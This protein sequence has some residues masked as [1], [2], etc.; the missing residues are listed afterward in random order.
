MDQL[1][2]NNKWFNCVVSQNDCIQCCMSFLSEPY[3][4]Y[5]LSF[6]YIKKKKYV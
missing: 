3:E 2:C 4:N 6:I 1:N 5:L